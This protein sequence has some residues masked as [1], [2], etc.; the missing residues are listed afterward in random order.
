MELEEAKDILENVMADEVIGIYCDEIQKTTECAKN[1]EKEDCFLQQ[2][3]DTV[4]SELDRLQKENEELKNMDLTTVYLKGVADEKERWRN[5]IRD[6]ILKI[7]V[8]IERNKKH[9]IM[10]KEE[11]GISEYVCKMIA[12]MP[13]TMKIILQNLLKEE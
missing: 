4:I 10:Y 7:D 1:C 5:N 3:I 11:M 2:A 12:Y 6:L 9:E 13:E 8:D